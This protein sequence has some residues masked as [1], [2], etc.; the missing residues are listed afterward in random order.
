M[1]RIEDEIT[2]NVLLQEENIVK[3]I[4]NLKVQSA[5]PAE[6]R[7]DILKLLL[8]QQP[9]VWPSLIESEY[10]RIMLTHDVNHAIDCVTLW[11]DKNL[12]AEVTA[13]IIKFFEPI[14]IKG[15]EINFFQHS[16]YS[17][18]LSALLSGIKE[19]DFETEYTKQ[20]HTMVHFVVHP[21]GEWN[22]KTE[23]ENTKYSIYICHV[24]NNGLTTIELINQMSAFRLNNQSPFY[25][26]RLAAVACQ[27]HPSF[28]GVEKMEIDG[29][30][31]P[32]RSLETLKHDIIHAAHI[33]RHYQKDPIDFAKR[34][35][36]V[37]QTYEKL[38]ADIDLKGNIE[39][40][41]KVE[42]TWF[43]FQHELT[44]SIFVDGIPEKLPR[45][46]KTI[47]GEYASWPQIF[48]RFGV[49]I[50]YTPEIFKNE[51]KVELGM[52]K[53]LKLLG[54]MPENANDHEI[55]KWMMAASNEGYAYLSKFADFYNVPNPNLWLVSTFK[56]EVLGSGNA[57]IND[58]ERK[59][60]L[61]FKSPGK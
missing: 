22:I 57:Q 10:I 12:S 59:E 2:D 33:K 25:S 34:F 29:V 3:Q 50:G 26:I 51:V 37:G 31:R 24:S 28:D 52:F 44:T 11:E 45:K 5:F 16:Y 6:L 41:N 1:Q 27:E 61:Q 40:K 53:S 21:G 13:N 43:L 38:S 19:Q 14:I 4:E 9:N 48:M 36:I 49:K 18:C 30:I 23:F 32:P 46:H 54:D 58:E 60:E 56:R 17:F 47:H 7:M 15:G 55:V 42:V 39:L 8:T 35:S 20:I